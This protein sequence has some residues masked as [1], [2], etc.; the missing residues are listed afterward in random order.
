LTGML[1]LAVAGLLLLCPPSPGYF[2]A[3]LLFVCLF[4]PSCFLF[5][6][7]LPPVRYP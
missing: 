5:Q 7:G 6:I 3:D 4:A 2:L 1:S